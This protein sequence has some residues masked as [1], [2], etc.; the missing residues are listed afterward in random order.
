MKAIVIA[1]CCLL[2]LMIFSSALDVLIG[3][4][5]LNTSLQ[6]IMNPFHVMER[7]E[8]YIFVLLLVLVIGKA[9]FRK[10]NSKKKKE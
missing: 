5:T 9:V 8:L 6:T 7:P 10:N 4:V 3:N 1:L 2:F